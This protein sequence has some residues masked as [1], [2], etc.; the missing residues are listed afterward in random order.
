M[1]ALAA[2]VPITFEAEVRAGRL[3]LDALPFG[4]GERVTVSISRTSEARKVKTVNEMTFEER[5]AWTRHLMENPVE[6]EVPERDMSRPVP[7]F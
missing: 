2:L 4:E 6:L 7:E 1:T 3:V 5:R